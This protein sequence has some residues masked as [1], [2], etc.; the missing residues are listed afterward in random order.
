METI[1]IQNL[2]V[3][4]FRKYIFMGPLPVGTK[5]KHFDSFDVEDKLYKSLEKLLIISII[6]VHFI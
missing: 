4:V 5:A 2:V 3:R 6:S 1:S